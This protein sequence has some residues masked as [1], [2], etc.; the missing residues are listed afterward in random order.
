MDLS[1][2]ADAKIKHMKREITWMT[3]EVEQIPEDQ[4]AENETAAPEDAETPE[5]NPE[6]EGPDQHTEAE[7]GNP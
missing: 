2:P 4:A 1:R 3:V 7:A 5:A 6:A